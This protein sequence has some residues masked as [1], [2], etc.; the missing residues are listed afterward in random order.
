M[1]LSHQIAFG[2]WAATIRSWESYDL[3]R[4]LR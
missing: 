2:N 1:G 3:F 4:P